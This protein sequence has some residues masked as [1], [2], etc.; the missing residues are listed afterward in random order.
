MLEADIDARIADLVSLI[1]SE[2]SNNKPIDF[3]S[4]A[5][6][7]TLD[8]LT[9][10]AFSSPVGY[11]TQNKDVYS[12]IRTVS[13]FLQILEL[14]ANCPTFQA[15]LDSGMMAPFRPKPTDVDGMGAM[16]G[17][18]SKAV[19]SRYAPDAKSVPDMLGS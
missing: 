6:Y 9:H 7:F 18:A 19:S 17:M 5:Q 2:S 8:V 4:F 11:L 3:A 10:I 16:M 12:Y 15:I 1:H 14:G 13:D